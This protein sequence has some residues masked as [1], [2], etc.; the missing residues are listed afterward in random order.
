MSDRDQFSIE[1]ESK[2]DRVVSSAWSGLPALTLSCLLAVGLYLASRSPLLGALLPA[3]MAGGKSYVSGIWVLRRDPHRKR[4]WTS[5]VFQAAVGA[6]LS[7]FAAFS[8]IFL[9]AVVE[10]VVGI[11]PNMQAMQVSLTVVIAGLLL[12]TFVAWFGMLLAWRF[13][14]RVWANP[15]LKLTIGEDLNRDNS[16]DSPFTRC[17]FAVF[18]A[19]IALLLPIFVAST[20]AYAYM[21]IAIFP[22][23]AGAEQSAFV[24]FLFILLYIVMPAVLTKRFV[25]WFDGLFAR[26]PLECFGTVDAAMGTV[27]S[28]ESDE[29]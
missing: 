9:F 16:D 15:K 7:A 26:R 18:T 20:A 3:L 4:A 10:K 1:E 2:V 8:S 12:N 17:N 6:F 21:T 23:G 28:S 24:I 27:L 11:A 22:V 14:V 5:A 19:F 13:G 25:G 29:A